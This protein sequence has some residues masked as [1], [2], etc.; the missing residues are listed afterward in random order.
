MVHVSV[1]VRVHL[2]RE[3]TAC[4]CKYPQCRFGACIWAGA[5]VARSVAGACSCPMCACTSAQRGTCDDKHLQQLARA[6]RTSLAL[7][8]GARV[9]IELA[10]FEARHVNVRHLGG[11]R[12]LQTLTTSRLGVL[13]KHVP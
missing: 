8:E 6:N 13:R 5:C 4:E 10:H 2:E 12:T 9:F 3:R 11:A 7:N 1:L